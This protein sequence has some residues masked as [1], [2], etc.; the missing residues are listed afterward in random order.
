V[1]NTNNIRLGPC[2]VY[3]GNVDL[4][5]T[6][7]GVEVDVKTDTHEVMVDQFGKTVVNELII[8]RNCNVKAPLAETTLDNLVRVMPGATITETGAT[9]ASLAITFSA[10]STPVTD[11]VTINGVALTAATAPTS[12]LQYKVGSSAADQAT[13]FAAAVNAL[14]D[15]NVRVTASV[16][17]AVVTLTADDYDSSFYSYNSVT[18]AKTGTSATFTGSTLTGGVVASK[19]KVTVPTAVGASLLTYAQYLT[20]HPMAN[21][22]TDKHEDFNIPLAATAGD[23]KFVYE[24]EKERIYEISFKAYPDPTTG[25]LFIIGDPSAT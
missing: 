25:N 6:S 4:G 8:G 12:P 18:V 3:F 19:Q 10:V 13:Q 22:D 17:G 9:K 21:A 16:A 5:Y 2:R 20:L 23:L 11:S 7:G 14:E 15:V 1:S 24:L